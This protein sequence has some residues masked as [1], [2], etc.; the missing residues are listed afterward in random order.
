[1]LKPGGRFVFSTSVSERGLGPLFRQA[2][3]SALPTEALFDALFQQG[4]SRWLERQAKRGRFHFLTLPEIGAH[5]RA[6]GFAD[7]DS[8][9]ISRGQVHVI[10]ARREAAASRRA[11]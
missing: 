7:W 11:A 3:R 9:A 10:C 8:Q 2:V 1:V 4:Y 6:A 5:L